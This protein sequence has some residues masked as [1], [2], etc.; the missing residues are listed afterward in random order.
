M[1]LLSS[2]RHSS[3]WLCLQFLLFLCAPMV[4]PLYMQTVLI[5]EKIL[6]PAIFLSD[7]SCSPYC[8]EVVLLLLWQLP[9]AHL[10]FYLTCCFLWCRG[11]FI[12]FLTLIHLRLSSA[13]HG[14]TLFILHRSL[15]LWIFRPLECLPLWRMGM[16][17]VDTLDLLIRAIIEVWKFSVKFCQREV[18]PVMSVGDVWHLVLNKGLFQL[19]VT[20]WNIVHENLRLLGHQSFSQTA[21][22]LVGWT[23]GLLARVDIHF[24]RVF[25]FLILI[26]AL[27]PLPSLTFAIKWRDSWKCGEIKFLVEGTFFPNSQNSLT[28][29]DMLLENHLCKPSNSGPHIAT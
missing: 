26:I 13:Y 20:K 4:L 9:A 27:F 12:K 14:W 10:C 18:L 23:Q 11:A 17:V 8:F 15:F 5:K 25:E 16:F 2:S 24:P 28:C 19:K 6:P 22:L 29:I 1:L 7:G 3:L 21:F